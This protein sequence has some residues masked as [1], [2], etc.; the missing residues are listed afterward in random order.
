VPTCL[1][2]YNI[3]LEF[4]ARGIRQKEEI[5]GIQSGKEEV[6]LPLFVD[7]MIL[8]LKDLKNSTQILLD[9]NSFRK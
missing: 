8:Y 1:F 7:D 3:V 2:L 4:L 6:K 5:K 9:H